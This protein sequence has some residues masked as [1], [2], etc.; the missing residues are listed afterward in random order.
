MVRCSW[1]QVHLPESD[2]LRERGE[3]FCC[4]AHRDRYLEEKQSE[5]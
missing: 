3:W 2:A 4:S 1:C 5:E